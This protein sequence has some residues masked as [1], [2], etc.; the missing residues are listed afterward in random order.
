VVISICTNNWSAYEYRGAINV[1]GTNILSGDYR[2]ERGLWKECG[3]RSAS[4]GPKQW[5][6][7]TCLNRYTE[8][9]KDLQNAQNGQDFEK[10][11]SKHLKAWEIAVLALMIGS[12]FLGILTLVFSPCCCNRCGCCLATWVFLAAALAAAGICTYAYYV[13]TEGK[14]EIE[15]DVRQF[16]WSFWCAVAG[17][18]AQFFAGIFFAVSRCRQHSYSHTI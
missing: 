6:H 17:G 14:D 16:G 2:T 18:G 4:V 9:W 12:G 3:Y 13:S 7:Y 10:T 15:I 5:D 8:A 1:G 11:L